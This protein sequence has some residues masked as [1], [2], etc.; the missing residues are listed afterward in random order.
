[1]NAETLRRR[2]E[3]I[4]VWS[5]GDER[6]P[7]KPLLLLYALGRVHRGEPRLADYEEVDGKL[8][9]LLEDFG[10]PRRTHHPEYPFWRLE[11]DGVWR[12]EGPKRDEI[13]ERPADPSSRYLIE[14]GMRGGFPEEIQELLAGDPELVSELAGEILEASF[15][16]TLHEDLLDEVG[17]ELEVR[18]RT[19]RVRDPAFREKVMRAYEYRCAVC[20]FDVRLRDRLVG[21]EAAHIKWHQAGGPDTEENGL[22]LCAL[23]HK[24]FDRGAFTV[25][26]ERALLVSEEAHGT[27]GIHT[28][29]LDHHGRELEGPQSEAYAPREEYLSW[30]GREVFRGPA[31]EQ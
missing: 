2:I 21:L 3:G 7:H 29:L 13:H 17:L 1:V 25:S 15:P 10:P 12:I 27:T 6:A 11:N 31:R 9:R 5:R 28:A 4:N 16:R 30:H 23:H 26:P 22:A 20:G 8:R 19:E 14:H 18:T 24:L